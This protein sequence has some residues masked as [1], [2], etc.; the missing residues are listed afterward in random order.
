MKWRE[1][2]WKMKRHTTTG[3]ITKYSTVAKEPSTEFATDIMASGSVHEK[4]Y[5][6]ALAY[7]E[8]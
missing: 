2:S 4:D 1:E 5:R 7:R 6:I 8:T 3:Q